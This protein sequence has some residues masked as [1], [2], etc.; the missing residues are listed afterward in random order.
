MKGA[1]RKPARRKPLRQRR[2]LLKSAAAWRRVL[3]LLFGFGLAGGLVGLLAFAVWQLKTMPVERVLVRGE[4]HQVSRE[5]LMDVVSD[6]IQG[7]FLWTDLHTIRTPLEQLPW[8]HRVVVKRQWPD[9][10]VVQV[11]EQRAIAHWGDAAYLNHAGEVFAP[12]EYSLL[13]GLPLLAGPIGSEGK[14]MLQ[15]KLIQERLQPQGLQVR[16][17][18]MDQRGGLTAQ[19]LRGGRLVFGQGELEAKLDRFLA[20]YRSRL[21]LRRQ[22]VQS[23]DLRYSHGAAVAWHEQQES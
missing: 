2:L 21:A 10:L 13:D 22:A 12:P 20:V 7:G 8:V 15:Y 9:S 1:T 14:V 16:Q 4:L 23:V 5:A 11:V 3:Q 19:L 6:S 18:E 17:L